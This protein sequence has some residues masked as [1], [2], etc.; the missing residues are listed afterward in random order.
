[1][2]KLIAKWLADPLSDY[3]TLKSI[4]AYEAANVEELGGHYRSL[5]E[6]INR[7]SGEVISVIEQLSTQE[8]PMHDLRFNLERRVGMLEDFKEQ[9][10]LMR[11]E[12]LKE[13]AAILE[14]VLEMKKALAGMEKPRPAPIRKRRTPQC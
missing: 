4:T 3:F 8:S 7:V 11:T 6:S 2:K 14:Q 9:C 13:V 12:D 10:G 1:M 5:A